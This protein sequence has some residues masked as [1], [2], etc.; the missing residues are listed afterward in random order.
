MNKYFKFLGIILIIYSIISGLLF[1]VPN[2]PILRETIRNLYF[3]V[4]MWF[5]AGTMLSYS[6]YCSI[7][8]LFYNKFIWDYK[9]VASVKIGL[10]FIFIGL[11][12]GSIWAK[13]TWG[14]YWSKDPIQIGAYIT[15][16]MYSSY[17]ILR[18]SINNNNDKA[19]IASIYNIFI[20]PIMILL[21]LIL[22]KTMD[23]L[24]PSSGNNPSFQIYDV[25]HNMKFILYS[26]ILGW[27]IIG[28]WIMIIEIKLI[29]LWNGK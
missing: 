19:N 12:S 23:S 18:N 13:F 10:L 16:L 24:H 15:M 25:D 7:N 21:I 26:S 20:Y 27:I 29:K 14:S 22:P 4:P 1:N 5:V 6:F 28:I 2:I 11:L 8:Y 9:A 3:H 17:I